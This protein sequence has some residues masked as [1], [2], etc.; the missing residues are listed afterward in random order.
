[1]YD[2]FYY[3]NERFAIIASRMVPGV[4]P[5]RYMVS[6]YGKV[7]DLTRQS[8]LSISEVGD[9]YLNV[10]IHTATGYMHMLVH[11]LVAMAFIPGDFSLQVNHIDGNKWNNYV[12]N[13]EWVTARQN[14][15]HAVETGLN[16][17]GEDKP[18]ATITNDQARII[19]SG[20]EQRLRIPEIIKNAGLED[21]ESIRGII[22][23]IKRG[24]SFTFISRGY[25]VEGGALR[26]RELT[27]DQ[28][29]IICGALQLDPT[30]T[31]A[32]LTDMLGFTDLDSKSRISIRNKIGSIKLRKA[33]TDISKD[34]K[35]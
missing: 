7:L 18:N 12:E 19:C 34:Y 17:R 5:Y 21:N 15:I 11:R 6:N 28:I 2:P 3:A 16:H 24:R 33:Y 27:N 14:L 8:I 20:L 35:W 23:D 22:A 29:R 25:N 32:K 1:M 4:D 9:G 13:L 10:M 30:L 26:D 31:P